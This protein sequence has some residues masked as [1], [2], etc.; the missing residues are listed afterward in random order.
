VIPSVSVPA[1]SDRI[2]S[3]LEVLANIGI[4][5]VGANGNLGQCVVFDPSLQTSAVASP[6]AADGAGTL[7]LTR[8][9]PS[10][11][12]VTCNESFGDPP[13]LPHRRP[14]LPRPGPGRGARHQ[15]AV[16]GPNRA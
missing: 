2:A 8:A 3:P 9:V 6:A 7:P 10:S 5:Q 4:S 1:G 12:D 16:I 14:R 13:V 11:L 15:P